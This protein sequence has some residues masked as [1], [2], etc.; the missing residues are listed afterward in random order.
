MLHWISIFGDL[1]IMM[2]TT[3]AQKRCRV[4]AMFHQQRRRHSGNWR[5]RLYLEPRPM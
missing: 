5:G 3:P 1:L 4:I 2:G